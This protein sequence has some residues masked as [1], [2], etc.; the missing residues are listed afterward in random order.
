[1]LIK[2]KLHKHEIKFDAY[3]IFAPSLGEKNELYNLIILLFYGQK[4]FSNSK[5]GYHIKPIISKK[6]RQSHFILSF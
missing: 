6:E 5:L 4:D 3:V 1:M 2:V